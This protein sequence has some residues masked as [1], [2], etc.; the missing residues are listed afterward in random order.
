MRL[1]LSCNGCKKLNYIDMGD[2]KMISYEIEFI[3]PGCQK[4]NKVHRNR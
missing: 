4:L 2:M 3:C 1:I